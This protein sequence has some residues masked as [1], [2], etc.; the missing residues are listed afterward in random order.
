MDSANNN[1]QAVMSFFV[2][3]KRRKVI[4]VAIAYAV[5]AWLL[6]EVTA[7]IFPILKL[8]DWTM[9]LVLVLLLIGFPIALIL[10][11]AFELMP[12]GVKKTESAEDGDLVALQSGKQLN[13]LIAAALV[14]ALGFIAYQNMGSGPDRGFAEVAGIEYSVA[15]LPFDDL[16]E[17]GDQVWFAD[18]LAEEVLHSL[19]RL[20]ELKV[21][22]RT[23]SFHFRDQHIPLHDIAARLGVAHIVEGS[24]RRSGARIRVTAQLIR[25]ED[26]SHIWTESYDAS[27]DDVFRVQEDIAEKIA[28]ALNVFLDDKKREAMFSMGTR[29]VQA[30]ELYSQALKLEHDWY[31]PYGVGDKL[32]H[33]SALAEEALEFDPDF[34]AARFLHVT[35]YTHFGMGDNYNGAPE[36]LTHK[37]AQAIILEDFQRAAALARNSAERIFFRL[38]RAYYSSDW[39]EIPALIDA[40]DLDAVQTVIQAT[41][42]GH[43]V[44]SVLS[45][46]GRKQDA[47]D[48]LE[49]ALRRS[50]FDPSLLWH[51]SG[52]AFGLGGPTAAFQH[53]EQVPAEFVSV[54]VRKTIFTLIAAGRADEAVAIV[55]DFGSFEERNMSA[56]ALVLAHAGRKAEAREILDAISAHDYEN[57][58]SAWAMEAAGDLGGA[59]AMYRSI[60]AKPGGPQV[61]VTYAT[62]LFGGKF[63]HNLAWTPNLAA[64]L[65]EAGVEPERLRIPEPQVSATPER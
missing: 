20:P 64:R 54:R 58:I 4:K 48:Y 31:E 42:S 53:I 15:V 24:V 2:E 21:I 14:A 25:A 49:E 40:L 61:L 45:I 43:N 19:A 36:G 63:F 41:V 32:W 10:A 7:T 1:K 11:W 6:I 29:N 13:Y 5:V 33:A 44:D 8:P 46:V 34:L 16:S 37:V 52:A 56:M 60:D 17:K 57:W 27:A 65:A 26:D 28:T 59:E 62:A 18:G 22:S 38:N 3:L 12:E 50:P 51:M 55:D 30:W 23:S 35:A 47:S 9:T 39:S